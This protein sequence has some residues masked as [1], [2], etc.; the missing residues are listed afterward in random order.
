MYCLLTAE[1]AVE[2]RCTDLMD[3]THDAK[4][5]LRQSHDVY[6]TERPSLS[7]SRARAKARSGSLYELIGGRIYSY[8]QTRAN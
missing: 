1:S 7:L 8:P 5:P 6:S 2:T 4:A 3:A